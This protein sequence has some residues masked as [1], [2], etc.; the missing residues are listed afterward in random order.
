M[1]RFYWE[2]RH[3]SRQAP[4]ALA[5]AQNW[6]RTASDVDKCRHVSADLVRAHV[7]AE[8]DGAALADQIRA[9]S[10]SMTGNIFAEPYYWAGFYYTGQGC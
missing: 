4:V 9:R 7:L 5:R 6:L 8:D 1:L 10:T 3:E 2:W